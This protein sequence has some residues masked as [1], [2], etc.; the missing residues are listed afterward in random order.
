MNSDIA[1]PIINK[2]ND[3]GAV[4]D[5]CCPY[6]EMVNDAIKRISY[7]NTKA[8]MLF[9]NLTADR[10]VACPSCGY[11]TTRPYP[12]CGCPP[13]QNSPGTRHIN[14][15]HHDCKYAREVNN[16]TSN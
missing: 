10:Q 4:Y 3:C 2:C 13:H 7:R 15:W 14:K 16:A 11:K 1:S 6:C 9:D 12:N 5:D 8:K